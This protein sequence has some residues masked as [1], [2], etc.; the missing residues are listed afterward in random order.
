MATV[1]KYGSIIRATF[2]HIYEGG[3]TKGVVPMIRAV[4]N[5]IE[6]VEVG[7]FWIQTLCSGL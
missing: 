7:N 2:G 4:I 6:A 5:I 3:N 1:A